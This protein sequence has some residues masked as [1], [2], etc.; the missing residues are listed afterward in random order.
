M[1]PPGGFYRYYPGT[2]EVPEF[3]A[4][5]TRGRSYKILAQ[6]EVDDGDVEGMIYAQGARFGGHSLFVKD[7][8]LWYAYNFIGPPPEQQLVSD[9]EI[10]PGKHV[11]GVEFVKESLGERHE[12]H[13]TAKLYVDDEVVAEAPL[14]TQPGHFALCG[15]GLTSAATAA[16]PSARSTAPGSR[17]PAGRSARSR[18]TSATTSTSTSSAS[19]P[20]RWRATEHARRVSEA[21]SGAGPSGGRQAAHNRVGHGLRRGHDAQRGRVASSAAPVS[22]SSMVA[23][24]GTRSLTPARSRISRAGARTEARRSSLPSRAS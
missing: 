16:T 19:S 24:I 9:R 2:L 15:E 4:A 7:R 8:R 10:G 21:P 1:I 6:V 14:R 5:N 17:S 23:A 20:R 11:L 3:A 22:A 18:S 12:T 13:G